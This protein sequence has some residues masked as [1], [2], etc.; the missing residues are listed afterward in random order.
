MVILNFRTPEVTIDCLRTLAAEQ[1]GGADFRVVLIDNASGDESV[2]RIREAIAA[3]GWEGWLDFRPLDKNLG[4]AGG[5][6]FA[7]RELV[8]AKEGPEFVL[9]LNSDTLVRPGCFSYCVQVMENDPGIGAL[10]CMLLNRDSSVQN[11]TRKHPTL[12]RELVR[13]TGLP[14]LCPPLFS[15]A[16]LDDLSWDRRSGPRDVEWIGGAF[17]LARTEALRK[18][19]L[20]D[21]EFFFYGEDTELCWRIRRAGYRVWFDPGAET[22]HLGGASSDGTR[23]RNREKDLLSWRARFLVQ[24]KCNG[25]AARWLVL[26]AYR[27]SFGLREFAA[28]MLGRASGPRYEG[29]A[30]GVS[31]LHV[32]ASEK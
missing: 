1:S 21:E 32:V 22:V 29:L 18:A 25:P 23:L 26:N 28:R 2:P 27:L 19:G 16:D 5:N 7:M 30:E 8:E 9:L 15:W 4:F 14:W 17:L 13:A 31:Q 20:F 10:S 6:N 11:V 3:G 24:K 12:M